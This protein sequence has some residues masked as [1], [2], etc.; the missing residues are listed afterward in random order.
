LR[1]ETGRAR[2]IGEGSGLAVELKPSR[3]VGHTN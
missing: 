2:T 1:C 3:L